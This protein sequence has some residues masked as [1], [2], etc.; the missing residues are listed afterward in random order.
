MQC[1][2][3]TSS[4]FCFY[5]KNTKLHLHACR[6]WSIYNAYINI[7]SFRFSI[8]I[9]SYIIYVFYIMSRFAII[10]LHI[11]IKFKD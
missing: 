9:N 11:G 1:K 3:I 10:Y 2:P 7:S 4:I 5:V 6:G 8:L